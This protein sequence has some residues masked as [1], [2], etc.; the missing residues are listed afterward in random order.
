MTGQVMKRT[1]CWLVCSILSGSLLPSRQAGA[2]EGQ[3][4]AQPPASAS[5]GEP[6][7]QNSRR[8][9]GILPQFDVSN[10]GAMV[11]MSSGQKLRLAVKNTVEPF[12][13]FSAAFKSGIYQAAD[14]AP[15]FGQG[16]AG[17]GKRFGASLADG[18]TGKML[19]T[20]ALPSLLHQDPRYFPKGSGSFKSRA[21]YS[22]TRVFVTRT[23]GGKSG[24]NWSKIL[25]SIGSGA[26]S[27][28]YYPHEERGAGLVFRNAG[29]SILTDMGTN[30]LKEFWPDVQ[31]RRAK[32][33]SSSQKILPKVK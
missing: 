7:K 16:A 14:W 27:N 11:P 22:M 6:Q 21:G 24:I 9:F 17:F 25:G 15:A 29:W 2:Q 8:M 4:T 32:K 19:C 5:G 23:D 26:I 12:A 28:T 13:V 30:V 20:F 33:K 31:I 1:L 3:Q 18:A 10:A